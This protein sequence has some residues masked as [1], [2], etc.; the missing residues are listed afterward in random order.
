MICII[1]DQKL[2]ADE[3]AARHK[4][5]ILCKEHETSIKLLQGKCDELKLSCSSTPMVSDEG[6]CEKPKLQGMYVQ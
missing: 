6:S 2:L 1:A 4:Y 5:Q 3:V